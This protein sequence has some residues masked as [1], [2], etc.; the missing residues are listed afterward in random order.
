MGAQAGSSDGE[1]LRADATGRARSVGNTARP[2][3]SSQAESA[4]AQQRSLALRGGTPLPASRPPAHSHIEGRPHL[5]LADF[6]VLLFL[7]GRLQAL[8]ACPRPRHHRT[9]TW[10]LHTQPPSPPRGAALSDR[11]DRRRRRPAGHGH[12]PAHPP[13]ARPPART[14][15]RTQPAPHLP[16]QAAAQEVHE[17]KSQ[18]L[19]VVPAALLDPK[20][21]VDLRPRHPPPPHKHTGHRQMPIGH[22]PPQATPRFP[23][24][25]RAAAR[26][27]DGRPPPASPGRHPPRRSEP[28]PSSFCSR[29]RGCARGTWGRGT[30]WRGRNR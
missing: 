15:A 29:S 10:T 22:T 18:A 17:H 27:R 11:S 21:R 4:R 1:R 7:G 2:G 20:V 25:L 12:P 14:H 13:H 26:G 6:V 23:C 30:S 8:Q 3:R 28:C 9:S 16:G 24:C 5:L 19:Q